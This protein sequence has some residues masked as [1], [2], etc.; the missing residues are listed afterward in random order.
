ML[1]PDN[2]TAKCERD[3][4]DILEEGDARHEI[5]RLRAE[6]ATLRAESGILCKAQFSYYFCSSNGTDNADSPSANTS[7]DR[8]AAR[9]T[10]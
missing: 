7:S 3:I 8:V 1:I 4:D 10:W 2:L 9:T 5:V 6:N